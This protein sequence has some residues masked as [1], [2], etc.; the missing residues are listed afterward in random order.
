MKLKT[1]LLIS[2]CLFLKNASYA[3]DASLVKTIN[4]S[5]KW[6]FSQGDAPTFKDEVTLP[7]SMLTNGKGDD[8]CTHTQWTGS[9]Y[10][11]SFYFNPYMQKYRMEET[12]ANGKHKPLGTMKFP[13]FLT[14]EKHYVGNAWYRKNVFVPKEWKK[15]R[16]VLFLE[17]PHI[18]TSVYVNGKLAGRDSSLSVAHEFDVTPYVVFGKDNEIMVKIY[19]GVENVCVGQ[20]SHSVTD[21]TQGNWNGIVGKMELQARQQQYIKNLQVYPD[22]Q[23]KQVKVVMDVVGD[24]A[25]ADFYF[26][27]SEMSLDA[28]DDEMLVG[29]S[30][31]SMKSSFK[32][33]QRN[34]DGKFSVILPMGEDVK[35]WD[36]FEPNLYTLTAT[37]SS[38]SKGKA[39][40]NADIVK[41]TFGMS[42][43]GIEGRQFLMNG[44]KIWMR[45]TVGNCCFPETGYPPTDEA[46]WIRIFKKCKE[47]GLNMMR[48]HTYCPPEAAFAAADKVGFYLQPEGPSWPN[49]GVKL[50]NGMTIDHYLMQ[51]TQRMVEKYGNHPS[52]CMLAAGN[53]P[54]GN[55][56]KWVGDFVDAWKA[57]GDKRRVYCGASV[58][59]GWAWDPKSEYHVKGGARGLDWEKRA[60]Q[61][62]D[63]FNENMK[64]ILQKGRTPITFENHEP[65][66]THEMG[67]WCAF[68]DLKET[69]Q[70]TGAYKARNFEIFADLLRDNGMASQAEKFLHASGKLQTLAYKYDIERNLR[71]QDY[72]GFQMLSLNDY[73]GQGTALVGVLNVHWNEKGY[74]SANDWREFCSPIVPLAKFPRFVFG[75]EEKT[76]IPVE[77]YNAYKESLRDAKISYRVEDEKRQVY[78]SGNLY[79]SDDAS[80]VQKDTAHKNEI[81]VGKNINLGEVELPLIAASVNLSDNDRLPVKLSLTVSIASSNAPLSQNH[82]EYWVYPQYQGM[83]Q[84]QK[85]AQSQ[86][87]LKSKDIYIADSLDAKAQKILSKGGKVLLLAAGKVKMGEDV[88][89]TYL[90]V[91]WNTSWFKMRPPHTTG[92]YIDKQHPLFKNFPTDDWA[93][94][95]WWELLNKAQVMN[96]REL[97]AD[98]QPAIQP[99]DTWHVSR[100]LGMMIEARVGKGKL[101]MTTMDLSS[102]LQHRLVAAQMRKAILQYMSGADFQPSLTLDA[103][104][105]T[106]FFTQS[107]PAV[108]M[109]TNDSPDELKPKLK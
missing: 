109:F 35:L 42:Q 83:G 37:M 39:A 45:G 93:N 47:Y 99:I 74:C 77:L 108:N 15:Q 67:Q 97:P 71:T 58:G 96:L 21:Q 64:K 34:A 60:P 33:L 75:S 107:A 104:V 86:E 100:K 3:Q 95:N 92:A 52:F 82:W 63:N 103:A 16:V 5:G 1:I 85:M 76:S 17:R 11:S 2:S 23:N 41:T 25:K 19:N 78:A 4:L 87:M 14:P 22:I 27:I 61:S 57:T 106:D 88:K 8:V 18:E 69:S 31:T 55:W 79:A 53:E 59:G 54:A 36:E 12:L 38:P 56:V 80:D 49:H 94:L 7:G 70:Y 26:T 20:D 90:P 32:K 6:Q 73:S 84:S 29:S 91:F 66:L 13:F 102:D 46:S 81:P 10:D 43:I 68:P 44:K 51:E 72:A 62:Q 101:L 48:F 65:F 24:A 89:Q 105:I 9:L 50:G 98:Y 30:A 40:M 28:S